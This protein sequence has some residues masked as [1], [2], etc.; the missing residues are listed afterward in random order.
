MVHCTST[1]AN[2][3]EG[4]LVTFAQVRGARDWY[5]GSIVS[6]PETPAVFCPAPS[7]PATLH[8]NGV[9]IVT[10]NKQYATKRM[11]LDELMIDSLSKKAMGRTYWMGVQSLNTAQPRNGDFARRRWFDQA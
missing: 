10:A 8:P 7:P 9:R 2:A 4:G 5:C 1:A 11:R 3:T 6:G